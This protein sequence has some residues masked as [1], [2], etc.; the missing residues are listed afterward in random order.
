MKKQK[1]LTLLPALSHPRLF[2]LSFPCMFPQ[3]YTCRRRQHPTLFCYRKSR[4]IY[5]FIFLKNIYITILCHFLY[6]PSQLNHLLKTHFHIAF[7]SAI[8]SI[9]NICS[10]NIYTC[11]PSHQSHR[12]LL[13]LSLPSCNQRTTSLFS[14][15]SF[16]LSLSRSLSLALVSLFHLP[17][18]IL[19]RHRYHI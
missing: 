14:P 13:F 3:L 6:P 17:L 16:S 11:P 12:L 18:K 10:Q 8:V 9:T 15:F 7:T 5:L 19:F 2:H 1:Q 4:N